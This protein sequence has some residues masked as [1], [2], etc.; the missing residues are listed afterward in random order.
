MAATKQ[1][2]ENS[3]EAQFNY[4]LQRGYKKIIYKDLVILYSEEEKELKNWIG[5]AA[6]HSEYIRYKTLDQLQEKINRL[7]EGA[8]AREKWKAEQK[9]RNKGHKSS[10][11]AAAAAIREEL[12]EHSPDF[13]FSVRSDSFAGGDSVHISWTDGPTTTEVDNIVKKYQYGHFDGM[14][15]MYENSNRRE[16]IPQSK[17][18][19]THRTLSPEIIN[20]VEEMYK[21]VRAFTTE[22]LNDYRDNPRQRGI[23]LL[24]KTHIPIK[25]K[26]L[27]IENDTLIFE[28]ETT[29]HTPEP[30][31]VPEGKIQIIKYSDKSIAVIGDTKK[32]KDIL[33]AVGGIFNPRLSCGMGWIFPISKMEEVKDALTQSITPSI[34]PPPPS[35]EVPQEPKGNFLQLES[36]KILW[37]EGRQTP[38]FEGSVFN[39]WQEVQ[40]A[41]FELWEVN[42]KGQDG[43]YTKVKTEIKLKDSEPFVYR[44]DITNRIN[45]GDFNPSIEHITTYLL[46]CI[47]KEDTVTQKEEQPNHY[48]NLKDMREAAQNGKTISLLNM[49]ELVNC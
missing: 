23:E 29:T 42:E 22:E 5:T 16:D 27:K 1:A 33:K 43:G 45:N 10:Q 3:R 11:A 48:D 36:F 34:T 6:N 41:F 47:Q 7:K 32:V 13:K 20:K 2:R 17:Y 35:P 9:E 46:N 21:Q 25:Y 44:F 18:V 30:A 12:K 28:E 19:S 4:Y 8:D 49:Y 31:P 26:S 14:N 40:Q 39:T 38:N 24:Y 37:H 15:D